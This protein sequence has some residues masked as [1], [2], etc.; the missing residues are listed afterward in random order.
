MED[1]L[2]LYTEPPDPSFPVIS[3]DESPTQLIGESGYR[4]RRRRALAL[5]WR[6]SRWGARAPWPW[7]AASPTE[8]RSK[9]KWRSGS[10]AECQQGPRAVALGCRP[11][12]PKACPHLSEAGRT[13]SQIRG[14][15]TEPV[16]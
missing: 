1:V 15:R 3:F 2:D 12:A 16:R 4:Y 8:Q 13:R 9:V 7:T 5:T 10:T 11:G 6:R 14:I